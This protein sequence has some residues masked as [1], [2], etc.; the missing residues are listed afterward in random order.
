MI[1]KKVKA[2]IFPAFFCTGTD[3]QQRMQA[4]SLPNDRSKLFKRK[5]EGV[6]PS[7]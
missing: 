1:C 6:K 7:L 2:G 3:N 5:R 4:G